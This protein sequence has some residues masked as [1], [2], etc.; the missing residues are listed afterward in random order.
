[1]NQIQPEPLTPEAFE[2]FGDILSFAAAGRHFP[3]NGGTTERYHALSSA[4]A[5]GENAHVILSLARAQ[6][7]KLPLKVSM[8]E[9][10][11]DGSQAFVPLGPARFIIVV[12]PDIFGKP[13]PARAFLADNG[14][15]INYF[16][17]TWHGVLSVLDHETDFLIV[18][19][20][21]KGPN[22]EEY[23]L[24]TPLEVKP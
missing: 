19:R 18:D 22:L 6:P 13:G 14:Q 21:G 9:R 17:N 16:R 8:L 3:I 2:P 10:H 11:P 7:V 5:F 15:G 20:E 4:V 23:E 12:A 1:M 24:D